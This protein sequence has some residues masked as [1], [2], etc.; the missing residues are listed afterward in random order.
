MN[1]SDR[2]I[3][4][5]NKEIFR[6]SKKRRREMN[7]IHFLGLFIFL[8]AIVGRSVAGDIKLVMYE[9]EKVPGFLE[10]TYAVEA[11][12]DEP[13]AIYAFELKNGNPTK[14]GSY[15]LPIGC[16]D[17]VLERDLAYLK[18]RLYLD[19]DAKGTW[20]LKYFPEPLAAEEEKKLESINADQRCIGVAIAGDPERGT[21]F[22]YFV[23][24]DIL[25][26][27]SKKG[28]KGKYVYLQHD[29]ETFLNRGKVPWS[30]EKGN[31]IWLSK[32][33]GEPKDHLRT[34]V[35]KVKG[36]EIFGDP[37]VDL[38][39]FGELF[40]KH[41]FRTNYIVLTDIRSGNPRA[42]LILPKLVN[43]NRVELK[44]EKAVLI[45]LN[46]DGQ[47][48][49]MIDFTG[50]G[51]AERFWNIKLYLSRPSWYPYFKA[52]SSFY[53]GYI[54]MGTQPTSSTKNTAY[55]TLDSK[56]IIP[57][58][59]AYKEFQKLADKW[60]LGYRLDGHRAI[61]LEQED[62]YRVRPVA[63]MTNTELKKE[64]FSVRSDGLFIYFNKSKDLRRV[65]DLEGNIYIEFTLLGV[66]WTDIAT[67]ELEPLYSSLLIL[68]HSYILDHFGINVEYPVFVRLGVLAF[69]SLKTALD[70]WGMASG[71]ALTR[72]EFEDIIKG[73][74]LRVVPIKEHGALK[75]NVI[76]QL[77]ARFEICKEYAVRRDNL[78]VQ[79][80]GP[81]DLGFKA[82]CLLH[83]L[84]KGYFSVLGT[85]H[86]LRFYT[87]KDLVEEFE[88]LSVR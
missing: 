35:W 83:T 36:L 9:D 69:D 47:V 43:K 70:E 29:S 10:C 56:R 49:Q 25:A 64:G 75:R 38:N 27:W 2:T 39:F 42:Y 6:K 55:I 19:R 60:G 54:D 48:T 81:Y 15:Y 46:D 22:P 17:Y 58:P 16:P 26:L 61:V 1:E 78:M 85:C 31:V 87:E 62:F 74:Y 77:V 67:G 40:L 76:G 86:Q 4:N 79:L 33:Q 11:T 68:P 50:T 80:R 32:S 59:A 14:E 7:R 72:E 37:T 53:E 51:E 18:G 21:I 28:W 88:N 71:L 73:R 8:F 3:R 52:Y 12:K 30:D 65:S 66:T 24:K 44:K 5:S 23:P 57:G 45:K 84:H 63:T 82:L 41:Q 20:Q 13:D 34:F